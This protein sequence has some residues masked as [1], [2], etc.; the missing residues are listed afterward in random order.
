MNA[1]RWPEWGVTDEAYAARELDRLRRELAEEQA[2]SADWARTIASISAELKTLR[3]HADSAM[4]SSSRCWSACRSLR[5]EIE[6]REHL[7]SPSHDD[8]ARRVYRA[9]GSRQRRLIVVVTMD[10]PPDLPYHW[11]VPI[12]GAY[13]LCSTLATAKKSAHRNATLRGCAPESGWS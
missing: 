10:G 6:V 1:A 12:Q 9:P 5:L 8:A 2:R 7:A 11:R 3:S 13:G 4:E